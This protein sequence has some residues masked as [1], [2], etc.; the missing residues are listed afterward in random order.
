MAVPENF[1]R[2]LACEDLKNMSTTWLELC[3]P[4]SIYLDGEWKKGSLVDVHETEVVYSLSG[5]DDKYIMSK[6][7]ARTTIRDR[8]ILSRGEH[9]QDQ[10]HLFLALTVHPFTARQLP[11][12]R[13]DQILIV[14]K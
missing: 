5:D 13:T 9:T 3:G 7:E 11:H 2:G 8:K 10:I 6:D 4:V 14:W 12:A 1:A